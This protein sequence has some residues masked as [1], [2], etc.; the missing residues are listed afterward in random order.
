MSS[1]SLQIHAQCR[2]PTR[3]KTQDVKCVCFDT[4]TP[5][6]YVGTTRSVLTYDALTGA[7]VGMPFPL[8]AKPSH[9]LYLAD[10]R[11]W[12]VCMDD[13][14]VMV[15]SKDENKVL[16]HHVATK[17]VER[18]LYYCATLHKPS[19]DYNYL[20]YVRARSKE[21]QALSLLTNN[22]NIAKFTG[23]KK[24][25]SCMDCHMTHPIMACS[26]IDGT[27]RVYLTNDMV[28]YNVVP[29]TGEG[30]VALC[31]TS[32]VVVS[33]SNSKQK[34]KS[35]GLGFAQLRL[36]AVGEKFV[37]LLDV[38]NP[39]DPRKIREYRSD[40][41]VLYRH[42]GLLHCLNNTF[43]TIDAHGV[44]RAYRT[45]VVMNSEDGGNNKHRA[46][47]ILPLH[48]G[49]EEVQLPSTHSS[50]TQVPGE[51]EDELWDG[52]PRNLV[53]STHATHPL[54][55]FLGKQLG[56]ESESLLV[57]EAV[58]AVRNYRATVPITAFT[59]TDTYVFNTFGNKM[60]VLGFPNQSGSAPEDLK[61][62]VCF[63]SSF[64]S[65]LLVTR[66]S[67][68]PL[69]NEFGV[70][71]QVL[72][73]G[74]RKPQKKMQS[75]YAFVTLEGQAPPTLKVMP[76]LDVAY[77]S[78]GAAVVLI[79][80][81]LLS[82]TNPAEE[83]VSFALKF[84]ADRLCEVDGV[85]GD[86]ICHA[87]LRHSLRRIHIDNEAK[88]IVEKTT[89][90]YVL[91]PEEI[92][93]DLV[94]K[95]NYLSV[96]TSRRVLLLDITASGEFKTV[97]SIDVEGIH[98]SMWVGI[99]ALL[100]STTTHV[101]FVTASGLHLTLC[102]NTPQTV[103]A[104]VLNNNNTIVCASSG[105]G[106]PYVYHRSASLFEALVAGLL[107]GND[108]ALLK[109]V[110]GKYDCRFAGT[111][112][113]KALWEHG[114]VDVASAAA[115][116][117]STVAKVKPYSPTAFQADN[118]WPAPWYFKLHMAQ[119]CNGEYMDALP[120][121][122]TDWQSIPLDYA[123]ELVALAGHRGNHAVVANLAKG[124][125]DG[126]SHIILR[127]FVRNEKAALKLIIRN[128]TL[129]ADKALAEQYMANIQTEAE[130]TNTTQRMWPVVGSGDG[131]NE[132]PLSFW[133]GQRKAK[134]A[135]TDGNNNQ[136][137][138][139]DAGS[140]A[141]FGGSTHGG[142]GSDSEDEG[143]QAKTEGQ[144]GS[145]DA[146]EIAKEQERLRNEF[147][148]TFGG[149]G[150]DEDDEEAQRKKKFKFVISDT[151]VA[152]KPVQNLASV[153]LG[154]GPPGGGMRKKRIGEDGEEIPAAQT[155][156]TQD[157][158]TPTNVGGGSSAIKSPTTETSSPTVSVE[159]T[160]SPQEC[161]KAAQGRMEKGLWDEAIAYLDRALQLLLQDSTQ[162]TRKTTILSVI[163]MKLVASILLTI[164][165]EET[166]G[167]DPKKVAMIAV[168]L[169][170]IP[171]LTRDNN[172]IAHR[173]ALKRFLA[174]DL[175]GLACDAART[176]V[177]LSKDENEF[178]DVISMCE[179]K[180][181]NNGD[182]PPQLCDPDEKAFCYDTYGF[183]GHGQGLECTYC[184]ANY[185]ETQQ[186]VAQAQCPFCTYGSLDN[187]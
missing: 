179:S 187:R 138:E 38:S 103:V 33:S 158:T 64:E 166:K 49:F 128:A 17:A 148:T 155:T 135:E 156:T 134:A 123:V 53:L 127:L 169:T 76:G 173:A 19:P 67:K 13:G 184:A 126:L 99:G 82:I 104:G 52:T 162:L 43:L 50:L 15:V 85:D 161:T 29:G 130:Q 4:E 26:A 21:V 182:F 63:E 178:D 142:G 84:Y 183:L 6:L 100:Y 86:W 54:V 73:K 58:D 37:W 2:L 109:D 48:E 111:S 77:N 108:E 81:S 185:T 39:G 35:K 121:D 18:R 62:K 23:H 57:Y 133:T 93:Y 107:H 90:E 47:N 117:A 56:G 12:V 3:M 36:L 147:I 31:F 94:M 152:R 32:S 92:L 159:T 149:G 61:S 80:Q 74:G 88:Q 137:P 145:H 42:S 164:Q 114:H 34:K 79:G 65:P 113:L 141:D 175:F 153:S 1:G 170:R 60:Q 22:K 120:S 20:F 163:R 8:P 115:V 129:P 24:F 70:V 27:I 150:D 143:S 40:G 112:T 186:R 110:V 7:R 125:P 96:V 83:G 160:M 136:A 98:S 72:D 101:G 71:L 176:L 87:T 119:L 140:G 68:S 11:A 172:V 157:T 167:A 28:L 51:K 25:I 14:G 131:P 78:K 30:Y 46:F 105:S 180:G 122:P 118:Q 95:K 154:L 174:A 171:K 181:L 69:K 97:V 177:P 116:L 75:F 146:D 102:S 41:G 165:K 55:V 132:H 9:L 59:P 10:R 44:C 66:T 168:C 139:G 91:S 124:Y 5:T 89:T 106:K 144:Q 151:A 16:A 45:D